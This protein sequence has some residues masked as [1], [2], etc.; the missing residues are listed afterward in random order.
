MGIP[1]RS[2]GAS[3]GPGSN[4][5]RELG[6]LQAGTIAPVPGQGLPEHE[7][8]RGFNRGHG[9]AACP[10]TRRAALLPP[11]AARIPGQ[12]DNVLRNAS[13]YPAPCIAVF[14]LKVTVKQHPYYSDISRIAAT[15]L[16][17][18]LC[19]SGRGQQQEIRNCFYVAS[20]LCR[21]NE[22]TNPAVPAC[23]LLALLSTRSIKLL[24]GCCL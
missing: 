13:S 22:P 2:S 20:E 21:L 19:F 5:R 7:P 4:W 6:W 3:S 16:P 12:H 8:A 9:H 18:A 15:G 10:S 14:I 24:T 17:P 23:V 11:R 1:R